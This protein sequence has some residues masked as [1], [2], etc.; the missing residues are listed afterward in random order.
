MTDELE[1]P[2]SQGLPE[3]P[4]FIRLRNGFSYNAD[5]D[6]IPSYGEY[7]TRKDYNALRSLCE[8]QQERIRELEKEN[9]SLRGLL[10]PLAEAW[11]EPRCNCLLHRQ[12]ESTGGWQCPVHGQQL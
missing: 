2:A 10:N 8:R 12:G 1:R 4:N 11:G 6:Q 9:A 5:G 7:V 3:E